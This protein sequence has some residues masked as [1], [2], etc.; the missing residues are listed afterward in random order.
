[1]SLTLEQQERLNQVAATLNAM[2]HGWPTVAA[3]LAR[4]RA[5]MV[6]RL[7][8]ADNAELRG[9]IKQIDE[10]LQLPNNLRQE[11]LSY[12]KALPE[13]GAEA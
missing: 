13:T 4:R 9:A 11:L 8:A 12:D 6:E 1:M 3:E 10:V 5:E 2:E 7:V